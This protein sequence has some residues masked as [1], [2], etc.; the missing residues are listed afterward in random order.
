MIYYAITPDFSVITRYVESG[1][2][3]RVQ[4]LLKEIIS[5]DIEILNA[6][7]WCELGSIGDVYNGLGFTIEIIED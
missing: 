2:I 6:S 5:N 7:S 4:E 1:N 3:S